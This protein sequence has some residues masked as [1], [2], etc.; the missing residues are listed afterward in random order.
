MHDGAEF[1]LANWDRVIAVNLNSL[2]YCSVAFRPLLAAAGGTIIIVSSVSAVKAHGALPAYT[3][4][5][6]AAS[7]LTRSLALA[8]AKDGIRVN[9]IAPGFVETRLTA[10][11][12]AD[13]ARRAANLARIP[14]GRAGTPD[15]MA[16]AALFL[17]APQASYINGQILFVDGGLT[18]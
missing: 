13:P 15:D 17:A 3:A 16:N 2:M 18:L 8:W 14:A 12:T 5:K 6:A 7:Q 10:A 4:S 9:G 1:D 11:A